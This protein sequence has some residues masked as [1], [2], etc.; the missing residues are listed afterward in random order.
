MKRCTLA[1][2]LD[3][4][5]QRFADRPC[6][7][8]NGATLTYREMRDAVARRAEAY[9]FAG[10]RPHDCVIVSIANSPEYLIAAAAAWECGAVHVGSDAE[11]TPAEL[12]YLIDLTRPRLIVYE[13]RDERED[14]QRTLRTLHTLH[15]GLSTA[16]VNARGGVD[17]PRVCRADADRG[18][19]RQ[20]PE[21]AAIIF[22]SSGTTGRPKATIGFHGNLSQRW[23]RLGDW[24]SFRPDDV[25][26]AHLPLSHGF[27]FMMAMACLLSGGRLV[28]LRRFTADT[29]LAAI[30][31][32]RVT[33]FN[34]SPTHFKLLLNRLKTSPRDVGR[35]RLSV[36]TAAVFP[37]SLVDA[38]WNDLAVDFVHM[39]GSSEG[40]GVATSDRT[41]IRLGSVGRPPAGSTR[42]VGA[43]HQELPAGEIGE[44]AFSRKVYPVTYWQAR[45]DETDGA[46]WFYSGDLGRMDDE[47]RLY[48]FGRLKHQIDRGG[49]KID[50]VEVERALLTC[51]DITDAAVVGLP[52]PILGETVCACVVPEGGAA[53]TLDR[54][55]RD[56]GSLLASYKL[57]TTLQILDAIPRTRLGKIDLARL[58][59]QCSQQLARQP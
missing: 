8:A 48:V 53:V 31:S 35:L 56:L 3:D 20:V 38:I 47:G 26:L 16:M 45:P 7:T 13:P 5:F 11:S 58:Q 49:L 19:D 37:P 9:R 57:P 42:I 2:A 30:A 10:I 29:A 40:V 34:G 41:D 59:A 28:T 1:G 55:R 44:I 18:E 6:V 33:V 46:L 25:H 22:I 43:D 24:L 4:A 23:S 36:G 27:G 14:G 54:V 50:P 39:Y 32:E 15:P 51:G 21:D 52:D 12:S 17:A